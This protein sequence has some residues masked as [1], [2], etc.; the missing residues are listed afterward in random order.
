MYEQVS[1]NTNHKVNSHPPFCHSRE[2]GNLSSQICSGAMNCAFPLLVF[3]VFCLLWARCIVLLAGSMNRTPITHYLFRADTRSAP[4]C[5]LRPYF[6]LF[7][8]F[9]LHYPLYAVRSTL[10]QLP[11]ILAANLILYEVPLIDSNLLQM[12]HQLMDML[13]FG[14]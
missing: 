6:F 14:F 11:A 4:T 8:S 10:V 9:F 12:V 7:L 13:L 5:T 1:K 3:T 2:S